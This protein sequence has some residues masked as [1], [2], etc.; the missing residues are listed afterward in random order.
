[1]NFR[2]FVGVFYYSFHAISRFFFVKENDQQ[3]KTN[4]NMAIQFN[5]IKKRDV[6][7]EILFAVFSPQPAVMHRRGM[8]GMV[9]NK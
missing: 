3:S 5:W 9:V 8:S 2:T 6:I 4:Q 7:S 1:M